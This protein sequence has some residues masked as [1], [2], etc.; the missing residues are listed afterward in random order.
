MKRLA[1]IL[2]VAL[3][4]CAP[5]KDTLSWP[6]KC[7]LSP[8]Y[9][10]RYSHTEYWTTEEPTYG[11]RYDWYAGEYKWGQTGTETVH[12]QRDIYACLSRK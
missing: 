6:E 2:L 9:S 10:W 11:Y 3:A 12:H 4:A 8:R 7:N 5:Y 1:A